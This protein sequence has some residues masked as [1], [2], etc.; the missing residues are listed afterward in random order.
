ME[1][2]FRVSNMDYMKLLL[3]FF[4]QNKKLEKIKDKHL[5]SI[6]CGVHGY[7]REMVHKLANY[8]CP[9]KH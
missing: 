6:Q 4:A 1:V 3:F 7:S 2:C 9:N 5:H 8:W